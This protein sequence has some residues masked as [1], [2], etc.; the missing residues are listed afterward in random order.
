MRRGSWPLLVVSGPNRWNF[1]VNH[2]RDADET[3]KDGAR[4][5]KQ[6]LSGLSDTNSQ[7]P[8]R[9]WLPAAAPYD[10]SRPVTF[11]HIPKTSGV[12]LT[13]ALAKSFHSNNLVGRFDT[14]LFG[15][16]QGYASFAPQLRTLL[17]EHW[18]EI[19]NSHDFIAGHFF[20]SS[21]FQ[22]YPHGQHITFLREARSRLLS[23]WLYWRKMTDLDLS[24]LG[25]FRPRFATARQ[26][27]EAFLSDPNVAFCTDNMMVRVLVSPHADLSAG[28][29][30]ERAS[31]ERLLSAAVEAL[32]RMSHADVIE[33][34]QFTSN[35]EEWLGQTLSYGPV[36]EAERMPEAMLSPLH[37]HF[38]EEA[39]GLLRERSRLDRRLWR[40][41][42]RAK[43]PRA[44][45]EIIEGAALSRTIARH[46]L[47]MI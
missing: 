44:D 41:L 10:S 36:N 28:E 31:D 14:V 30:I 34:P 40:M 19:P 18:S 46:A 21:L 35:L 1:S 45:A 38:T 11:V 5:V 9:S 29:F 16:F 23:N 20:A 26:S 39:E 27:L 37:T 4:T 17:C 33:N 47:L 43:A 3:G 42:L 8:A 13:Q 2:P 6:S 25:D 15:D 32:G 22:A 7:D 12:A 24:W